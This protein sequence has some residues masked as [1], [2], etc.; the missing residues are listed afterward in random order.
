[1]Y[2]RIQGSIMEITVK[3]NLNRLPTA[4]QVVTTLL[5]TIITEIKGQLLTLVMCNIWP[6]QTLKRS[7]F[8]SLDNSAK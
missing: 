3:T 1:M 5:P 6:M 7:N 4:L 8:Y 2:K